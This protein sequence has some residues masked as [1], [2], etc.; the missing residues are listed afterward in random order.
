MASQK[1][2]LE[3]PV[4]LLAAVTNARRRCKWFEQGLCK[5]G[6]KCHLM[7]YKGDDEEINDTT[8]LL[9]YAS[10]AE[11]DGKLQLCLRPPLS[12]ALQAYF[13]CPKRAWDM[14]MQSGKQ[15][16]SNLVMFPLQHM[17][18][19]DE[20]VCEGARSVGYVAF[21]GGTKNMSTKMEMP[22]LVMHGTTVEAAL[23]ICKDG[24]ARAGPGICGD[25]VYCF[26][27]DGGLDGGAP[28]P[29]LIIATWKNCQRSGYNHG[30][31][32]IVEPSGILVKGNSLQVVP[33]GALAFMER[34][35][36]DK[37]FTQFAAHP[38]SVQYVYAL[39][40][41]DA[42]VGFLQEHMP[43]GYSVALHTALRRAQ[44]YIMGGLAPTNARLV[45]LRNV[46]VAEGDQGSASTPSSAT[47]AAAAADLRSGVDVAKRFDWTPNTV[48]EMVAKQEQQQWQR[49]SHDKAA[50]A[51]QQYWGQHAWA[52]QQWMQQQYWA[53]Q[54]WSQGLAQ[55]LDDRVQSWQQLQQDARH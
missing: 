36:K 19:R 26:Q 48:N 17:L 8:R 24:C 15:L 3:L 11:V 1:A 35:G 10:A 21:P 5:R 45:A 18:E 39:F 22:K 30:A 54:S 52:Q 28:D 46:A 55:G 43:V 34:S 51:Q 37:T 13:G 41:T 50:A 2:P 27:V 49:H 38:R 33:P 12:I 4:D 53:G 32:I 47:V 7:H 29:Q 20:V 6:S 42:L 44:E 40:I 9:P 16:D 25:G 23:S 14:P 31:A